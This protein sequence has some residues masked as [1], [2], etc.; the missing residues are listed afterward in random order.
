[1]ILNLL[2]GV[3][4]CQ[5]AIPFFELKTQDEEHIWKMRWNENYFCVIGVLCGVIEGYPQNNI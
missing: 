2:V 4:E 5:V 1:M 3:T